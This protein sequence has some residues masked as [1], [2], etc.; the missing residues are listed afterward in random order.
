MTHTRAPQR[1]WVALLALLAVALSGLAFAPAASAEPVIVDDASFTWAVSDNINTGGSLTPSRAAHAPATEDAAGWTFTDGTGTYD[2]DTGALDVSF[3]GGLEFGNVE[4][5]NYGFLWTNPRLVVDDDGDGSLSFDVANRRVD[6]VDS[7]WGVTESSIVVANFVATTG[8]T[9]DGT[10]TW[11]VTPLTDDVVDEPAFV[12]AQQFATSFTSTLDIS[13]LGHFRQTNA[14]GPENA[15]NLGKLP[16]PITFSVSADVD[17]ATPP[18]GPAISVTPNADLDPAGQTVTIDGTGFEGVGVYVRLCAA[19]EGEV[20]T[21]E[22]RPGADDCMGSPQHWVGPMSPPSSAVMGADGT[23]SVELDVQAR[24][25][26]SD[27]ATIDCLAVDCVIAVRRDH[28]GGA[29]DFSYDVVAAVTFAPADDGGGDDGDEDGDDDGGVLPGPTGPTAGSL[30]WGLS[31]SFRNYILHGPAAGTITPSDGASTLDSGVF[32][33]P[34]GTDGHYTS[35]TDLSASFVGTVEF[36]G[37]DG[38]LQV[39]IS[40]PTVEITGETGILVVDVS[41][42]SLATGETAEWEDVEFADLDTAAV[43]PTAVGNVVTFTGIPASLTED[44]AEAFAGFYEPGQALDPVSF[45][46]E[47]ADP[48]DLP[49]PGTPDPDADVVGCVP[50]SVRAGSAIT[51]CGGGFIPGEQV[52]VVL[53][54]DPIVLGV[55]TA[56]DDGVVRGE[57]TIPATAP[58]G[59]HRIQLLGVTSGRSIFSTQIVVQDPA[60]GAT[61]TLPRTGAESSTLV[62]L[63]AALLGAGVVATFVGRRRRA[64]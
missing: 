28:A 32:R 33:F 62:T 44:G 8:T 16:A 22:G 17:D 2:P 27:E 48:G 45:S 36:D 9:D 46:L 7:P 3:S 1:R 37:H 14:A 38:Q 61:G 59:T 25:E 50:S 60:A 24:F 43:D 11:T 53:H 42:R 52:Q 35:T 31:T 39:V 4:Q 40:D 26:S 15:A 13:L 63:G 64:A 19:V 30:D 23:F 20:G 21:P 41:S 58:A 51:V 10:V 34:I 57:V 56:G 5:G 12:G 6:G 18:A 29:D 54:S 55:L 47:V 49:G